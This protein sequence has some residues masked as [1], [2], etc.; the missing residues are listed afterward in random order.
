M[1]KKF[2]TL[3]IDNRECIVEIKH[4]DKP[5]MTDDRAYV[6]V[7][8][9]PELII[10]RGMVS[11]IMA[12]IPVHGSSDDMFIRVEIGKHAL[13]ALV[14]QIKAIESSTKEKEVDYD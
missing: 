8:G 5:I 1:E 11:K 6:H 9:K 7:N 10:H 13:I 2:A 14:E 12:M 4:Y 3:V